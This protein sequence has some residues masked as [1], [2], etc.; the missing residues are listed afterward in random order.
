MGNF[1]VIRRRLDALLWALLPGICILCNARSGVAADLCGHCRLALPWLESPCLQC[2]LPLP[3]PGE[4]ICDAC[5]SNPPPYVKTVAA[6]RYSEPVSRMIHRVKFRGSRVDARVLGAL[7]AVRVASAYTTQPLPDLVV[8]VPLSHR[9]LMRRGH[10]QAALLAR[11]V[12]GALGTSFDTDACRRVRD[13]P[14]QSG[15]SRSARPRNL[16][17]AFATRRR[18]DG[19]LIAVVDDVMTTGTTVASLTRTLLA[20]DA[21][22]VHVWAAARTLQP[23]RVSTLLE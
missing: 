15:L 7:V 16:T 18:F 23:A 21:S 20:E 4:S 10:N 2:A 13:T 6:F 14:P 5:R 1:H 8:P 22:E 11:W 12:V 17:D 19:L 9:R 3:N